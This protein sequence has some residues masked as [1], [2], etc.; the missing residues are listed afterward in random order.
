MSPHKGTVKSPAGALAA[1]D[2]P[3][4]GEGDI[5]A[6]TEQEERARQAVGSEP[7][8]GSYNYNFI[9][10]VTKGACLSHPKDVN[11]EIQTLP[12]KGFHNSQSGAERSL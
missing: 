12:M 2:P 4:A 8:L 7:A 6:Q 5:W 9:F 10:P 11:T 3:S 1:G